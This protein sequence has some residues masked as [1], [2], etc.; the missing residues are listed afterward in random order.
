MSENINEFSLYYMIYFLVYNIGKG[1]LA[2][3]GGLG[4]CYYKLNQPRHIEPYYTTGLSVGVTVT[5]VSSF[6]IM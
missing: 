1:T 5:A 6:V 4:L 3:V 2:V